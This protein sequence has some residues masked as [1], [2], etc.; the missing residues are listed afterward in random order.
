MV[1]MTEPEQKYDY[2]GVYRVVAKG[3]Q[4][5]EVCFGRWSAFV[6]KWLVNHPK[7]GVIVLFDSDLEVINKLTPEEVESAGIKS[8]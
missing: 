2:T 7:L 5:K 4:D 1:Q 3:D 8:N 6:E